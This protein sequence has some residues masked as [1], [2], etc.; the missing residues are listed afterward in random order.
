M[1]LWS[2]PPELAFSPHDESHPFIIWISGSWAALMRVARSFTF[3]DEPCA[4]AMEAIS[5]ACW[6]WLVISLANDTSWALWSLAFDEQAVTTTS[7]ANRT[8]NVRFT[9]DLRARGRWMLDTL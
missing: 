4:S 9:G 8:R 3:A 1:A 6:W 5:T 7:A 2:I